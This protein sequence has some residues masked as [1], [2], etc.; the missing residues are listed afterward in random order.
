MS[1]LSI[2]I[3]GAGG[4]MGRALVRAVAEAPGCSLAGG[5][6]APNHPDQGK[7]LGL[8]A[9]LEPLSILL[10]DEADALF[11]A[12]DVVVDFTVPAV[13]ARHAAVAAETG[14]PYVVGTTGL[15][16]EQQKAIEA[17]ARKVPVVQAANFSLGVNLALALTRKA[18]AVLDDFFDIE[19]V[20]MHHRHKVDAPSGT[21]LA[22]GRAAAEGRGV[23]LDK[24]ADRGR[25]G[26]TGA[27]K[28]GD[29]GFAV[30]RGGNV[31]GDHTVVFAGDDERIEI[32]HKA[33]DRMIFAR[34]AIRAAQW[35]A[36][37]PAGLYSVQ[38]M[39]GL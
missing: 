27:R 24:V 17:A 15:E 29:I 39:L 11:G 32:S 38:D 19:I 28:R 14:T 2:G 34:G 18:A 37:K 25:D 30:L 3:L 8:L 7:D 22:L 26:I 12:A 13:T 1:E 10:F 23:D 36:G 33:G 4:R 5:I 20:E 9:G 16:A 6:D 31:P 35:A 21:A